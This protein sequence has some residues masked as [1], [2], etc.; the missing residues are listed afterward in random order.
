MKNMKAFV[1][2]ALL[3]FGAANC[4]APRLGKP[5]GTTFHNE[6]SDAELEKHQGVINGASAQGFGGEPEKSSSSASGSRGD[7]EASKILSKSGGFGAAEA[8]MSLDLA[9][10][11]L[12]GREEVASPSRNLMLG[13]LFLVIGIMGAL[14]IRTYLDKVVPEEVNAG[15]KKRK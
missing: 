15:K 2:V 12:D 14:G 8:Q 9:S 10:K 4:F 11:E 13:G 5:E 6:L 3:A 7:E 1:L